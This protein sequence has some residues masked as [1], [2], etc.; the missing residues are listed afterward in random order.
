MQIQSGRI[1]SKYFFSFLVKFHFV[2]RIDFS[3]ISVRYFLTI[4]LYVVFIAAAIKPAP[5]PGSGTSSLL[6]GSF[7]AIIAGAATGFLLMLII[8]VIAIKVHVSSRR[9]KRESHKHLQQQSHT[10][11]HQHKGSGGSLGD[12]CSTNTNAT[13]LREPTLSPNGRDDADPDVISHTG[14]IS[15]IQVLITRKMISRLFRPNNIWIVS[16]MNTK[17]TWVYGVL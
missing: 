12:T 5:K 14:R 2:L 15:R 16:E 11:H 1:L 8:V 13:Q 17:P 3:Y 9:R 10:S 6:K 4:R 7:L